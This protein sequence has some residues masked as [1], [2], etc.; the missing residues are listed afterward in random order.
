VVA[1]P[2]S[3]SPARDMS[4]FRYSDH[5]PMMAHFEVLDDRNNQ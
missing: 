1:K 4:C 3:Q 5:H 2:N